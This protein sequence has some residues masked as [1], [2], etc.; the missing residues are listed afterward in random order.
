M[1]F[2]KNLM[3]GLIGLALMAAPITASAQDNNRGKNDTHRRRGDRVRMNRT[4]KRR[5]VRRR[6]N[7]GRM[8]RTRERRSVRRR[9]QLQPVARQRPRLQGRAGGDR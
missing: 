8:S 1:K 2:S 3:T 6:C 9:R 5:S 7:H 4:P